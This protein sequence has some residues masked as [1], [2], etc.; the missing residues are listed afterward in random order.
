VISVG[1]LGEKQIAMWPRTAGCSEEQAD[2]I[3]GYQ[4]LSLRGIGLGFLV[5]VALGVLMMS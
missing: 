3:I 2:T 5:S 4:F 1:N